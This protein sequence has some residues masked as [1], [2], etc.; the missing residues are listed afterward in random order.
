MIV[1]DEINKQKPLQLRSV[2]HYFT[3]SYGMHSYTN[4][5]AQSLVLVVMNIL[6][7]KMKFFV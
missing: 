5:A 3:Q 2:A 7:K 4:N 1:V 6:A